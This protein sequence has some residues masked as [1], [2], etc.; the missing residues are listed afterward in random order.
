MPHD[1]RFLVTIPP[2]L[3]WRELLRRYRHIEELG[4]DLGGVA[5]HFVDYTG[6]PGPWFEGWT[7][8]TAIAAATSRLRLAMWVTQISFRNPAL[9]ARQA[10]TV[11]HV[12][13]GR[14]ELGPGLGLTTDPSCDMMG[15][16][17][18]SYRERAARFQEYV[19]IVDRLLR[20]PVTTYKGRYYEVNGAVMDPR[21]VQQPRPPIVIAAMR[22]TMLRRAAEHADNWNSVVLARSFDA[23]LEETRDRARVIDEHCAAIG[24]DLVSLRRSCLLLDTDAHHHG[25]LINY[26]EST[27]IFADRARRLIELGIS[28]IGVMYP[29][30]REQLPIFEQIASEIIP[31]LKAGYAG[32][33]LDNA[34]RHAHI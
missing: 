30:S 32:R 3:A 2:N 23:E 14:L 7:L 10:L 1:L 6:A 22:P 16:P 25:G 8:L 13:A 17:N 9:L 33:R 27:E 19:E 31:A 5:D 20:D 29:G 11:D 21:P 12:S 26:Y 15:L 28:E 4:F 24:R 34:G 18:W